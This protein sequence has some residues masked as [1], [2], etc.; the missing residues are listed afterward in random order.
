MPDINGEYVA[1]QSPPQAVALDPERGASPTASLSRNRLT[2]RTPSARS[3][4]ENLNRKASDLHRAGTDRRSPT[5]R[6]PSS[7]PLGRP[8]SDL[9]RRAASPSH[10]NSD[11]RRL[12]PPPHSTPRSPSGDHLTGPRTSGPLLRTSSILASALQKERDLEQFTTANRRQREDIKERLQSARAALRALET[13]GVETAEAR[14]ERIDL[15]ALVNRDEVI[16]HEL[17]EDLEAKKAELQLTEGELHVW[18]AHIVTRQ[19][20]EARRRSESIR[21]ATLRLR[22]SAMKAKA[23]DRDAQE[24]E[25]LAA[26]MAKVKAGQERAEVLRKEEEEVRSAVAQREHELAELAATEETASETSPG[27]NERRARI[28]ELRHSLIP[29]LRGDAERLR[30]EAS[31]AL[32][33]RFTAEEDRAY[34]GW[35]AK[36]AARRQR[37]EEEEQKKLASMRKG[38]D[39]RQGLRPV[40]QTRQIVRAKTELAEQAA[41]HHQHAVGLLRW[42]RSRVS[43]A[44]ELVRLALQ[45]ADTTELLEWRAR[46]GA[47]EVSVDDELDKVKEKYK[48]DVTLCEMTHDELTHHRLIMHQ[49]L[50]RKRC[51][52]VTRRMSSPDLRSG[53]VCRLSVRVGEGGF[54]DAL[55]ALG[56]MVSRDCLVVLGVGPESGAAAGGI[57]M[58]QWELCDIGGQ[59]VREWQ[60]AEGALA[61]HPADSLVEFTFRPRLESYAPPQR[62]NFS[63][64]AT[65]VGKMAR[66]RKRISGGTR[67][68]PLATPQI[69]PLPRIPSRLLSLGGASLSRHG[70]SRRG[71]PHRADDGSRIEPPEAPPELLPMQEMAALRR[72]AKGGP[73]QQKKLEGELASFWGGEGDALATRVETGDDGDVLYLSGD[74]PSH[75]DAMV[76]AARLVA[77]AELPAPASS[78]VAALV[79]AAIVADSWEPPTL[80]ASQ[81][82]AGESQL[83]ATQ[84]AV[85]I[86]PQFSPLGNTGQMN[87][88]GGMLGVSGAACWDSV[89]TVGQSLDRMP[90]TTLRRGD[91]AVPPSALSALSFGSV[92]SASSLLPAAFPFELVVSGAGNC[93]SGRYHGLPDA[94]RW[95]GLPVWRVVSGPDGKPPQVVRFLYSC[96][97]GRW[98]FC[99]DRASFRLNVGWCCSADHKGR[100]PDRVMVWRQ[101]PYL[102]ADRGIRVRAAAAPR[103][104]PP[105]ILLH[106]S[107]SESEEEDAPMPSPRFRASVDAARCAA[108]SPRA[109]AYGELKEPSQRRIADVEIVRNRPFSAASRPQRRTRPQRPGSAAL[110][111]EQGAAPP[112]LTEQTAPPQWCHLWWRKTRDD[113]RELLSFLDEECQR[114]ER[115]QKRLL[116]SLSASRRDYASGGGP[117]YRG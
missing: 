15:V 47:A 50:E 23:A 66:L 94:E 77:I 57:H 87:T 90:T 114:Q 36:R 53:R 76:A 105:P 84:P 43:H 108:W 71:S 89:S 19:I 48:E 91:G 117:S 10:A 68:T 11:D 97:D 67:S 4:T 85:L 60:Q 7:R 78:C 72:M 49:E 103:P 46:L 63:A 83:S 41:M 75:L 110:V 3:L 98:R 5:A 12:S 9:H 44:A 8:P 111:A 93:C 58:D 74:L 64:A 2:G 52:D 1:F 14:R 102:P 13:K 22:E 69:G 116:R 79:A 55:L 80:E 24:S 99:A 109:A 42:H 30:T 107:E 37:E 61:R 21:S 56:V 112:D 33:P 115:R 17:D 82:R 29:Q 59:R 73:A 86:T 96:A 95:N 100:P 88:T 62:R 32:T 106:V 27:G 70:S 51:Q 26:A 16:A 6:S 92:P 38:V 18:R 25:S 31:E 54:S 39:P 101:L 81:R 65:A 45:R 28:Q 104:A 20:R 34:R 35:Q 113:R 40:E